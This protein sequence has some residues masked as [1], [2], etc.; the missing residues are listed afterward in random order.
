MY[1]PFEEVVAKYRE[2]R[3]KTLAYVDKLTDAD[4]DQPIK[5]PP[6]GL[7]KPFATV[8]QRTI[9]HRPAS[10]VS[11]R[12][13]ICGTASQRQAARIRAH[14]GIPRILVAPAPLKGEQCGSDLR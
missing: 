7:E 5:N 2:L 1:P 13:V 11:Q 9:D 12:R 14:Q 4:L 8:G 10:G 3:G 6:P